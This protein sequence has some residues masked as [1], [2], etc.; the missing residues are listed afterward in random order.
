MILIRIGD[1]NREAAE[2]TGRPD[3]AVSPTYFNT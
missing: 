1:L 3:E 2:N